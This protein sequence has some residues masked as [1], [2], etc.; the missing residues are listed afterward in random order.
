MLMLH[1][2]YINMGRPHKAWYWTRQAVSASVN[3]GLHQR[4]ADPQTLEAKIWA[5]SWTSERFMAH[6]LGMPSSVASVHAGIALA[7]SGSSALELVRWHLATATGKIIDRDQLPQ[8]SQYSTTVQ[9]SQE[10]EEARAL[11][12]HEWWLPSAQQAPIADLFARQH[13]KI[14]YFVHLKLLHLPFMLRSIKESKYRHSWDTAMSASRG[15]VEAYIFFREAQFADSDLCQL[16]DFSA[17]SCAIVLIIG[18]MICPD[19]AAPEAKDS[20][21]QLIETAMLC[22]RK[23]AVALE[24]PVA[25]Q[26]AQTLEVLNAARRGAY[27]SQDDY[28]AV[29]PYFGKVRNNPHMAEAEASQRAGKGSQLVTPNMLEFST[30]EFLTDGFWPVDAGLELEANWMDTSAFDLDVDW[31]QVFTSMQ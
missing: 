1:K 25:S 4:T 20:D 8:K 16:M 7:D 31:G 23:T 29:I 6:I 11:I 2:L 14:V 26:A 22:L 9:I 15:A 19:R 17:F 3:L 28:T 12:P 10:F 30:H 24:C 13:I 27:V 21:W 5:A 18:H